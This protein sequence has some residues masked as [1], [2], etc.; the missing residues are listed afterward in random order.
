[1][2]LRRVDVA[3]AAQLLTDEGYV[4]IDVRP[5]SEFELGHPR[6]AFNVPFVLGADEGGGVNPDFMRVVRHRFACDQ[7][8][9]LGCRAGIN[10]VPA[11]RRLLS[12]G[13]EVA[14]LRPGFSGLRDAFNRLVEPG[15]QAAGQPCAL[16]AEAGRDYESLSDRRTS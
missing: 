5:E 16:T 14:E 2:N 13:Y 6:G 9:L 1:M 3:T 7:K 15:W 10:S 4:Y 8:L 12:A 11:A